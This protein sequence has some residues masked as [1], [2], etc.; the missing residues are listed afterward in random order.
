MEGLRALLEE[1]VTAGAFE[2]G[3][4]WVALEGRPLESA[5]TEGAT[6]ETIWDLASLTKPM[7]V[8]TEVMKGV[9]DGRLTLDEPVTGPGGLKT[10]IRDL[11]AHRAG[12]PAW[13]DLWRVAE[14]SGDSWIPGSPPVRAAVAARIGALAGTQAG[15]CYSDLGFITLGW[16]LE[17][18]LQAPLEALVSR[19]RWGVPRGTPDHLRCVPTGHCDRRG[20]QAL[21]EVDD[22]NC[23]VLGGVAGHAGLFATLDEV[24]AW[25]LDLANSAADRGGRIDGG[26]VREFWALERRRDSTWVLGWDT[27]TPPRS[28]AGTRASATAVG[29]LGFTGTSVW[30]DREQDLVM[31]LLSNRVALGSAS[32]TIMRSF[33]PRFHDAIRDLVGR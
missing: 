33:R 2:V 31:V 11:L 20:R 22:L 7:A 8:V 24:G 3:A 23:W 14:S 29:H 1:G 25:A 4:A 17:R 9:E 16:H 26:V 18:R 12:L 10:T 27:P 28:T 13:D 5:Y 6:P 32:K 30:I 19:W 21:G 15:T